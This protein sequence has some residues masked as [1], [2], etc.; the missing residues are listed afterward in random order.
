MA[1]EK[2]QTGYCGPSQVTINIGTSGVK[3]N[4]EGK[5]QAGLDPAQYVTRKDFLDALELRP[6]RDQV[7]TQIAGVRTDAANASAAS[8]VAKAAAEEARV[9][10]AAADSA[11]SEA[12]TKVNALSATVAATPRLLRLDREA[13]VPEGTPVGTIIVRPTTPISGGE[14]SFPPVTEWPGI[15]A[16]P[17]GDGVIVDKDHTPLHPGPEQMRSAKGTWDIEIR[18]SYHGSGEGD[19]EA[20]VPLR[21]GRLWAA[22]DL[23]EVRRGEEFVK[24]RAFPGDNKLYKAKI[25]PMDVDKHIGMFKFAEKWG[26][27]IE[28]HAPGSVPVVIH[29]IKVTKAA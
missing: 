12:S 19:E 25:T 7:E 21:I 6:T 27:F 2:P 26:P 16:S 29:D 22:E 9:R 8:V 13:L 17:A 24:F 28:S 14:N 18:Y 4:D 11:S 3:I 5:P 20:M 10:A 1:E 15:T 23:I